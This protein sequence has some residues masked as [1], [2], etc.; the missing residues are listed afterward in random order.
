[1]EDGGLIRQLLET[2][3]SPCTGT[4]PQVLSPKGTEFFHNQLSFE[5]GP[6]LPDESGAQSMPRFY[7]CQILDRKPSH[8]KLELGVLFD[9][10][11][12]V[13]SS[14]AAMEN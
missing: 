7:P 13:V 3:S 12:F 5:E 14:Y 1:M 10:T 2:E 8:T 11:K 6:K 9:I 4:R